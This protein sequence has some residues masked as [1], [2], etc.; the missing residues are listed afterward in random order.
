V[1]F[2]KLLTWVSCTLNS[3]QRT[4][5]AMAAAT[6][7]AIS[8]EIRYLI[9]DH[10]NPPSI[11]VGTVIVYPKRYADATKLVSEARAVDSLPVEKFIEVDPILA[12]GTNSIS[13]PITT[14]R[15]SCRPTIAWLFAQ[16]STAHCS[17]SHA[18]S[19]CVHGMN[20]HNSPFSHSSATS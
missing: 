18:G 20:L 9:F 19:C 11:I 13:S 8:L 17:T 10:L 2:V 7:L 6:L 1:S 3:S 16:D 5:I 12:A 15:G 14:T 4:Q